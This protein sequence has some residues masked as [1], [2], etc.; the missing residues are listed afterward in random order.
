MRIIPNPLK[1]TVNRRKHGWS[2]ADVAEIFEHPV[3]EFPDVRPLGYE[4]ETLSS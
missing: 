1:E 2:F 3:L 4:H